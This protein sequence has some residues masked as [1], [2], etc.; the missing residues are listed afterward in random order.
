MP[1]SPPSPAF[2]PV[3]ADFSSGVVSTNLLASKQTSRPLK[4]DLQ[5][6]MDGALVD[7]KA[8]ATTPVAPLAPM[9]KQ[10]SQHE[11]TAALHPEKSLAMDHHAQLAPTQTPRLVCA[12]SDVKH[13]HPLFRASK[14]SSGT[15]LFAKSAPVSTGISTDSS[16][17]SSVPLVWSDS[18][19]L[20]EIVVAAPPASSAMSLR[21]GETLTKSPRLM[22]T[23][24]SD[25]VY[26][27]ESRGP[28]GVKAPTRRE[29][30]IKESLREGHAPVQNV[31]GMGRLR[32]QE[33]A[34][35]QQH[36]SSKSPDPGGV[37][38]GMGVGVEFGKDIVLRKDRDLS[39]ALDELECNLRRRT[40]AMEVVTGGGFGCQDSAFDGAEKAGQTETPEKSKRNEKSEE[41]VISGAAGASTV[42]DSPAQMFADQCV[43][44]STSDGFT[45]EAKRRLEFMLL[46]AETYM[47][48]AHQH[49]DHTVFCCTHHPPCLPR[50]A[51]HGW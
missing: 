27:T 43:K 15:D 2:S 30:G 39:M 29:L 1:P 18:Q 21:A 10:L 44:P 9:R 28:L 19:E 25:D 23:M 12:S 42:S 37:G 31:V 16:Q 3:L 26:S 40:S 49:Q 33:R 4:F 36:E 35:Q 8:A 34:Q 5:K 50:L 11:S 24:V 22:G 17:G 13:S 46:E 32:E 51:Q 45:G 48:I 47:Q 41:V 6:V 14:F 7:L 38:A 20:Q